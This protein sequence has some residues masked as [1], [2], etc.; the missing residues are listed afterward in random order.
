M[1]DVHNR[2]SNDRFW[3]RFP[4]IREL[5]YPLNLI[6]VVITIISTIVIT[7]RALV[8][9]E[10][11]EKEIVATEGKIRSSQL[12]QEKYFEEYI[13]NAAMW[14]ADRAA[15]KAVREYVQFTRSGKLHPD[16]NE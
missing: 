3:K 12:A 7:S 11:F 4:S 5:S 15:R 1:V 2:I 16:D 10:E 13:K 9:R 8:T 14:A 6:V